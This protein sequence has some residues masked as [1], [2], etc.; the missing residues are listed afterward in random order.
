MA[1]L[2]DIPG[3]EIAVYY[4][5]RPL[6]LL[7][8]VTTEAEL[9]YV[10]EENVALGEALVFGEDLKTPLVERLPKRFTVPN[11][12]LCISFSEQGADRR[13]LL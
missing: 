12:L 1:A 7:L 4:D 11:Y 13:T 8:D 5:A 9:G 6:Q 2:L 10:D 3:K